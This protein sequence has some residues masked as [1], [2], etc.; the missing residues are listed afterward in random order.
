MYTS[1]NLLKGNY[2]HVHTTA[3]FGCLF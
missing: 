3:K 2:S 1:E